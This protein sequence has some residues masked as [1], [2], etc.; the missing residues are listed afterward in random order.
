MISF[1]TPNPTN[2]KD[3]FLQRFFEIIPGFFT[4]IT[5]VGCVLLSLFAP[6]WAAIVIIAFDFYW[7]FRAIYIAI[8]SVISYR[9]MKKWMRIDWLKKVESLREY[10]KNWRD[11]YHVVLLPT[12]HE[13]L[14]IIEPA[15]ESILNSNYPTDRIIVVLAI[16]DRVGEA[17]YQKAKYLEEKYKDKFCAYIT[18]AHPD[19]I[20]GEAKVK[21][22]NLTYAAKQAR[23][24]IDEKKIHYEDVVVSAFDCDTCAHSQYFACVAYHWVVNDDR[25]RMSYQPLPMFH[26]NIWD[27]NAFVRVIVTS[28][29]FWHMIENMRPE[30]LVT[31]SSH[32]MSLQA[33]VEVDYWPVNVI[34]DDSLIFWKCYIA[35]EGDYHT[36][37]IFLPVSMD[38]VLAETYTKTILNQ[39][40]QKRRWAY[41]IEDFPLVMRGF[42][43]S[44]KI[45]LFD[46]FRHMFIMLEGHHSWATGSFVIILL[47]WPTIYFGGEEFRQTILAHNLPNILS[48]LMTAAMIGLITSMF[49]SLLL[50]PP[51]PARYSRKRYLW[52]ILQWF[53]TPIIAIP[54]G[55]LPAVDAQTRLMFGKYFVDFWV[56][57][58][59][60]KKV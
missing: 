35:Y 17:A 40:K 27:T 60:R 16:E 42:L 52:M 4:W 33:L 3:F 29:S 18:S 46:K 2:R 47:G 5:L 50:L 55:A 37:P 12:V 10:D 45:K 25:T 30:R 20:P 58:K 32:A 7:L 43:K 51:R 48:N 9:K 24:I 8:Y 26:N 22:A 54:L 56:T 49:L 36:V 53:L 44:K 6:I 19:K 39:Y 1:P 14:E 23:K 38:A 21:G 59:V 31:F 28:S 11:L 57:D 15:I 13:G 34:S 41:G